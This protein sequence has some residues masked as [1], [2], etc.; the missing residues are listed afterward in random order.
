TDERG[1]FSEGPTWNLGF[2]D[3]GGALVWPDG[4]ALDGITRELIAGVVP[5]RTA[6]VAALDGIVAAFATGSGAGI[7]PIASI[8]GVELDA[9][10][11]LLGEIREAYARIPGQAI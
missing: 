4:D 2:V 11:P 7:R 10:H 6:P 5:G 8:D 1:V 9:N 3:A